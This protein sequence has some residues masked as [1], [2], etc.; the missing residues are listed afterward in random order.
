MK[1]DI[2]R[3]LKN[4]TKSSI[5]ALTTPAFFNRGFDCFVDASIIAFT[6]LKQ[7]TELIS[8]IRSSSTTYQ[9]KIRY[10]GNN[11]TYVCTCPIWDAH[12]YCEHVICT[13]L[14][15]SNIL[16]DQPIPGYAAAILKKQLLGIATIDTENQKEDKQP[17]KDLLTLHLKP[18]QNDFD[19]QTLHSMITLYY[20]K[21]ELYIDA[22]MVPPVYKQFLYKNLHATKREKLLREALITKQIT[23][24]IIVHTAQGQI[25][26]SYDGSFAKAV[27]ELNLVGES[28]A[29]KRLAILQGEQEPLQE[30]IQIGDRLL[31]DSAH[32][33]LIILNMDNCWGWAQRI[34]RDQTHRYSQTFPVVSMPIDISGALFNNTYKL[35]EDSHTKEHSFIFK[36]DGKNVL[37]RLIQPTLVIDGTVDKQKELVYLEPRI[38]VNGCQVSLDNSLLEYLARIDRSLPPLLRTK[39]RRAI[40]T[41]TI[42]SLIGM[43]DADEIKKYIHTA[44]EQLCQSYHGNLDGWKI[45]RFFE[46]FY[47]IFLKDNKNQIIA[48]DGIFYCVTRDHHALW[49]SYKILSTFLGVLYINEYSQKASFRVPSKLFFDALPLLQK[50]AAEYAIEIRFNNKTV[51]TVNLDIKIDA[52]K[53][54]RGHDWFD[55]TPEIFSQNISLTM[56]QRDLLCAGNGILETEESIT[57]IDDQTRE[58]IKLLMKIFETQGT[59]GHAHKHEIAQLPRLRILDLLELRTRGAHIKLDPKDELLLERLNN[60]SKISKI[61]LPEKFTGTLREYQIIGYQ[62]LAF[63]YKHQFGGCLADDMGLGKT[64]QTIAFLGGIAEGIIESRSTQQVPHLVVVPPT[65]L[66]N[67]QNEL[68]MFYPGLRVKVYADTG[69]TRSFDGYD[70]VLTTYD[71]VRIDSEHL[72]ALTFHVIILDEA[73]AIKNIHSAR[74]AAVRQLKGIFTLSLT[75]TPLENHIGEYYSIVDVALPGLL[76]DYNRFMD[77]VQRDEHERYIKKMNIFVL[78]RTKDTILKDL[79]PKIEANILLEMTTRQKKVY[80]TTVAA[81][82]R[83]IEHAYLTKTG[84]QATITALSALMR[85]RQICISPQLI[86][87]QSFDDA[88]KIDYLIEALTELTQ[89]GHAAL[90]FSQFIG[91]LD[92]IEKALKKAGLLYYRIDGSIPRAQRKKIIESFQLNKDGISIFLV[93]LKT[94]GVGLNLTRANYVFHLDPW[95]NP[96]VENQAS[97]RAHRIGQSNT[98]FITRLVMHHTIEEK[99]MTLKKAKQKLF[100]NIMENTENKKTGLMSKKDF[101][102]LLA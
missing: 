21:K 59:F 97:D 22:S 51:K 77:L 31:V 101:D 54:G 3:T 96:A 78:R 18:A 48:A 37:P 92:L 46:E 36:Q 61:P 33:K 44:V 55:V 58:I 62:W 88:P 89:E 99:M 60:F 11:L 29:I 75:G 93:S 71:T 2:L 24:P 65:L 82:K 39:S 74:T 64:I 98:V 102:F 43:R 28:I 30:I 14:T 20:G 73:Q 56:E 95:W 26:V 70:I 72:K 38:F 10:D 25:Q 50:T 63:L 41:K 90:V 69:R 94:G 91:C 45:K 27:V 57:L 79:P 4:F 66:F 86:D 15:T 67:W 68:Q 35:Y 49:R 23:V 81:V 52:S 19:S 53:G 42:F 34:T 76:P 100:N 17:E 84:T 87:T 1:N 5:S 47:D 83:T 8:L 40:I 32:K 7:N 85:L 13:L 80:T 6:W 12:H 9:I 16:N